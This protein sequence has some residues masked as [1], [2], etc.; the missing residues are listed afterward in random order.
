LNNWIKRRELIIKQKKGT[1]HIRGASIGSYQQLERELNTQ[2]LEARKL[3]R[4]ISG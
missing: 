1:R 2:F 4:I 3:G